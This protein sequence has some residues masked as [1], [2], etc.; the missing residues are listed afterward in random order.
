MLTVG[1]SDVSLPCELN[2]CSDSRTLT[3]PDSAFSGDF[4]GA[5]DKMDSPK[6]LL[7]TT[8][9]HAFSAALAHSDK[10]GRLLFR[11][12]ASLSCGRVPYTKN[13]LRSFCAVVRRRAAVR[14]AGR[15][16]GAT[17]E[18]FRGL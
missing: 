15:T 8:L 17:S 18:K 13:L 9:N 14:T 10:R 16:S 4:R 3:T 12:I 6:A 1:V 11:S 7:W 2:L 5:E